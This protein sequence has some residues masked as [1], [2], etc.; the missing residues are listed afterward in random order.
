MFH[1]PRIRH[2]AAAAIRTRRLGA[3]AAAAFFI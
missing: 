2:G 1:P 3:A